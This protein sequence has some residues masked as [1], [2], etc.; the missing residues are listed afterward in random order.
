M[1]E[2]TIE[3]F[4][5]WVVGIPIVAIGLFYFFVSIRRRKKAHYAK[6][7]IIR[8]R[9]CGF[10]FQNKTREKA[11]ECPEC[12]RKNDRGSCTKFG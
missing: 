1:I 2:L 5:L 3:D 6:Q 10:L 4:I 7:E 11:P 9:G 12:G 8:C